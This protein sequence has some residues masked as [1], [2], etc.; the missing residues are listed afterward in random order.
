M[1]KTQYTYIVVK[2]KIH[3]YSL[4]NRHEKLAEGSLF[5]LFLKLVQINSEIFTSSV[6]RISVLVHDSYIPAIY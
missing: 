3:L 1:S 5:W 6:V 2:Y 4:R